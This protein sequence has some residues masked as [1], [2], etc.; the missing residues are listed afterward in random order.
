M[1]NTAVKRKKK[2]NFQTYSWIIIVSFFLL[3]IVDTRF[4]IFGVA[5]MGAPMYH[6]LKGEGKAHCAK[7]CPR[8]SFLGRF[9]E[10]ISL[11]NNLPAKFRSRKVKH[12]MLVLMVGLLSFSLSHTGFVFSHVAFVLLRFM[13]MSFMVGILMGV[14]F[15][16]RTWCQVCPMGHAAGLIDEVQKK[17]RRPKLRENPGLAD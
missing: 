11:G 4:G 3:G 14:V 1:L 9:L 12:I 17:A 15:K 6:A 8:G 13:F 5:C 2:K 7:Y 10:R 16:P